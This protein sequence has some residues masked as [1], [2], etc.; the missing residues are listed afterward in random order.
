[1]LGAVARPGAVLVRPDGHV[2]WVGEGTERG[3]ADALTTWFGPPAAAPAGAG[4]ARSG[5]GR[6]RTSANAVRSRALSP[7]S[8]RAW[9]Q[10]HFS[11]AP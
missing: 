6:I 2:A 10:R 4:R 8:Y 7:L 3:L 1:M 9:L 11:W 5:P